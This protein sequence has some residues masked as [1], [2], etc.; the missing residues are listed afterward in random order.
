ML[1]PI[2]L[3]FTFQDYWVARSFLLD[4]E[5]V[6]RLIFSTRYIDNNVFNRPVINGNAYYRLQT[7]QLFMESIALST[8]KFINTSLIYSY[9]Q[10]EDIP[11][12]YVIE[13]D[14]GREINEFKKSTYFGVRVAYGNIFN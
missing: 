3:L 14:A 7:Y 4:R 10:T 8:Q 5:H 1:I 13:G 6:T 2:P 11:Y 9:G 12:G